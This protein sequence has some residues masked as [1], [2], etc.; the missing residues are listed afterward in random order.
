[1]EHQIKI[2]VR[3][4]K[5]IIPDGFQVYDG[6]RQETVFSYRKDIRRV[7]TF[8]A[9]KQV[10]LDNATT[11]KTGDAVFMEPFENFVLMV[12]HTV[13]GNPTNITYEVQGSVDRENWFKLGEDYFQDIVHAAAAGD[14][15][16]Y[17][18]GRLV[19]PWMRVKVTATGTGAS[20]TFTASAQLHGRG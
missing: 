16:E 10:V 12:Q 20:D 14:T 11:T 15:K 13:S 2:A 7:E 1:M 8:P 19:L 4:A 5:R 18:P 17:Y 3:E 6:R 9:L